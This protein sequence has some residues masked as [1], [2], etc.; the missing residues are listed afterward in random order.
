ML[1]TLL[2]WY[3][4]HVHFTDEDTESG[5][6]EKISQSHNC[7]ESGGEAAV[8]TGSQCPLSGSALATASSGLGRTRC[9]LSASIGAAQA[10]VRLGRGRAGEG[11]GDHLGAR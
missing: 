11:A 10:L 1:T 9:V 3:C 2:R 6:L 5:S 7:T 4:Y 8:G